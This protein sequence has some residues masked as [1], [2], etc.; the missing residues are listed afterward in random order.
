MQPDW[1]RLS[2]RYQKIPA[3]LVDAV[4]DEVRRRGP[5]SAKQL[6]DH[7]SVE[8]MDWAG[9]KGTARAA[10]MALE[11]LWTRCRVVVCG[12]GR[13]ATDGKLWDVPER[14][15]PEH[16]ATPRAG[17]DFARWAIAERAEA[18][19]LLSSAAGPWWSM[20][21]TARKE[22]V[23]EAMLAEGLLEEVR[24]DGSP[25]RWLAPRGFRARV[26]GHPPG[27]GRM[28]IL[29]PLDPLLWD[30]T[31]LKLAFGFDYVWEVY[32]PAPQRKW[33]WYVVPLLHGDELVGRM[34]AK[35]DGST[36]VVERLWREEGRDFDEDAFN[37]ALE[38]HAQA[39]GADRVKRKR[40]AR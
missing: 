12:R 18:A 3:S 26:A 1:W 15:L 24:V 13:R 32:K 30:R 9:W 6:G 23:P 28:R 20:L 2:E 14:A 5:L 29:G 10:T 7:G 37:A 34:E 21:S 17:A 16:A 35:V 11:I 27:D 39:C 19:G 31:L 36:L 38:R 8:P 33:G 22:R 25:R 40:G 4:L